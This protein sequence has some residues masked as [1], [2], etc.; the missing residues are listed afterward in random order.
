M[1]LPADLALTVSEARRVAERTAA[2]VAREGMDPA[3]VRW[4]IEDE[5]AEVILEA[6]LGPARTPPGAP[7]GGAGG[8]AGG[9]QAPA[10]ACLKTF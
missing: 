2:A 4:T 9:R 3:R 1:C 10:C 6:A 8:N 5:I 7:E